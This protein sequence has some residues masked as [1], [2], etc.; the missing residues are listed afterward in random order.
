[1][2]PRHHTPGHGITGTAV[3][4][5]VLILAVGVLNAP[6]AMGAP[7]PGKIYKIGV[8]HPGSGSEERLAALREAGY[9]D[10]QNLVIEL[11]HAQGRAERLPALARELVGRKPDLI[12]ATSNSAIQAAKNATQSIPIVMAFGEDPVALGLVASLARPG[13][14]VTGVTL[15]A[16]GTLAAK[17]MELLKAALPRA[18]RIALLIGPG[19]DPG[20]VRQVQEAQ[21]AARSLTLETVLVEG[22]DSAY[23]RAFS[24]VSAERADALFVLSHPILNRDRKHIIAL[25]ARYRLPAIYEWRESAE[26]GGLMAY[27]AN[28]RD[29]NRRVATFVDK[30]LNGAKP[31]ELP[32][33]QPTTFELIV[34]MTTAR[35]LGLTFPPSLLAQVH[36][37]V[38]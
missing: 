5:V 36:H 15:T 35:A 12:L 22:R 31:A 4:L 19:A 6:P 23:E 7:Q 1:M 27:G 10:G 30:I 24:T 16:A 17:R 37:I 14:N 2:P 8:L 9:V 13:G 32:V 28:N 26:E 33:E 29:L 21:L 18:R 25:A 34:N 11:R 20:S 38:E 3:R